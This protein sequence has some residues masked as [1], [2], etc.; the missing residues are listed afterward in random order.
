MRLFCNDSFFINHFKTLLWIRKK[1]ILSNILTWN[2]SVHTTAFSPPWNTVAHKLNIS[3]VNQGHRAV[4]TLRGG[5][6]WQLSDMFRV[7]ILQTSV[8]YSVQTM[9]VVMIPPHR[10]KLATRTEDK[11]NT[12]WFK[13]D[14]LLDHVFILIE[15]ELTDVAESWKTVTYPDLRPALGR[16]WQFL[17]TGSA[18]K[19]A[20]VA[21]TAPK[22]PCNL[23]GVSPTVWMM[24]STIPSRRVAL[25]KRSSKYCLAQ[26]TI[27][28]VQVA[29]MHADT[30]GNNST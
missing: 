30:S 11:Y 25:L 20:S 13:S 12:I 2:T 14:L 19:Q 3:T 8:Q 10:S 7:H 23:T 4:S 22:L 21:S 5:G 29:E 9:P 18:N 26:Q 24:K 15:R 17:W 1:K 28:N 16:R 6:C 27:K